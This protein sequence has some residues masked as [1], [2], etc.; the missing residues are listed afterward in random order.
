MRIHYFIAKSPNDND[1][2]Y[3]R[4]K[5][6]SIVDRGGMTDLR[7]IGRDWVLEVLEFSPDWWAPTNSVVDGRSNHKKRR[8]PCEFDFP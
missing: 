7:V 4:E 3:M 2:V 6:K 8:K 5:E 1:G